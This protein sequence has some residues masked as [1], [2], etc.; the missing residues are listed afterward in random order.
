M[1]IQILI[2]KN[3]WAGRYKKDLKKAFSKYTKKILF[4][5][6]HKKLK[7]NFCINIIFSYFKI[8]DAKYLKRSKH[9]LI[10]HESDLPKGRGMSPLSWQILKGKTQVTFSLL[11][12]DKKIDNGEI[13]FKNKVKIK[14]DLLF[15]DIKE[16][17]LMVNISLVEKFLKYFKKF[18]KKPKSYRQKGQA[19][20]F[21]KRTPKDS[22]LNPNKSLKSQFNLMRI[23]DYEKYPMYFL[24]KGKK[25]KLKLEKA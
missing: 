21:N 23:C 2:S 9:N 11:E 4:F 15:R 13:Y 18:G 16:L 3:S 14:K 20:F 6:D 12:A 10:L 19:T 5:D 7:K 22:R 17:Q 24:I 1:N 8:I 25:F